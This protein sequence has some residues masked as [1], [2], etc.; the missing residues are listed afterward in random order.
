[1]RVCLLTSDP[2][3]AAL[4]PEA[5]GRALDADRGTDAAWFDAL[6]VA[7]C[8]AALDADREGRPTVARRS[9]R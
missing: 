6:T 5:V 1:V 7:A 9:S 3:A 8:A 2:A 4:D